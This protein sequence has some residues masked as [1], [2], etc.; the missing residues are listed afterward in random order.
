MATKNSEAKLVTGFS[1]VRIVKCSTKDH[2]LK[3][4]Y[5]NLDSHCPS[6]LKDPT[7]VSPSQLACSSLVGICIF[8]TSTS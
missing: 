4:F 3:V 8:H 1:Q 2:V 6:C 5:I 7:I